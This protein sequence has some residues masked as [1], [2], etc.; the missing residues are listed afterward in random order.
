MEPSNKTRITKMNHQASKDFDPSYDNYF[1]EFDEINLDIDDIVTKV[2]T[3]LN[4]NEP[5]EKNSKEIH[6]MHLFCKDTNST[7]VKTVENEVR[8]LTENELFMIIDD[9][10]LI[11]YKLNIDFKDLCLKLNGES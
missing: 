6:E 7:D 1:P 11:N 10:E 5:T 2:F 3:E 9:T 8:K 4:A